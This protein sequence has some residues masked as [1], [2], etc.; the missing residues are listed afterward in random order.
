MEMLSNLP[1]LLF[2]SPQEWEVWLGEHHAQPHGVWLKLAKKDAGITTVSYAGALDV[3]LCY[4]WIDGQKRS[5]DD[6]FFLQKFTPRRPRSVWSKV[7][8]EKVAQLIAA[9]RMKP[10]GLREVEAAR[11][12]GRWDAAYASQSRAIVPDD[13]RIELERHPE[14]KAFFETLNKVNRYAICYRIETARKPETR[15]ARIDR[16]ISMLIANE[17]IHP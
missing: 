13:F 11:Q 4:G 6:R 1:L 7:N 5:Y 9:G 17:K 8:T 3:A 2:A 12:D 16:F 14:A 10:A 15:K